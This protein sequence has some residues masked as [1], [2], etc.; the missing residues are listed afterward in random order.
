MHSLDWIGYQ[1]CLLTIPLFAKD[2]IALLLVPL[3]TGLGL[4]V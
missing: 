4:G 1:A 2:Y 3:E